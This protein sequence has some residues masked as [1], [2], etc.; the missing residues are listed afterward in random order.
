MEACLE[1]L[2]TRIEL[3][4]T[5]ETNEEHQPMKAERS[6]RLASSS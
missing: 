1:V 3:E 6:R 2:M 4:Q 5:S